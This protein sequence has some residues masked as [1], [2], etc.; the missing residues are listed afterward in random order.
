MFLVFDVLTSSLEY[1]TE[2]FNGRA[3]R[4]NKVMRLNTPNQLS[5]K[6]D[7]YPEEIV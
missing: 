2:F 3:D 4:F 7:S 1:S 6:M 5:K